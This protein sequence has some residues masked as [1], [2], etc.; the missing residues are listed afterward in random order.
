MTL[1]AVYDRSIAE[2][3]EKTFLLE[4]LVFE[5]SFKS[6]KFTQILFIKE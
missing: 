3:V 1:E 5:N 4:N 2:D 6:E